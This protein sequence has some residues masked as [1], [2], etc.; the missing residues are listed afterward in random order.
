MGE[1]H[2]AI[3]RG[4]TTLRS[5]WCQESAPNSVSGKKAMTQ[6]LAVNENERFGSFVA[7]TRMIIF[8]IYAWLALTIYLVAAAHGYETAATLQASKILSAELRSGTNYRV[9]EKVSNDGYLNTYHINSK[10]GTFTVVST[11]MLRK[12][13]G[14]VSA[15]VVMEKVKGTSEFTNALSSA[16]NLVTH[17][18]DTL[19]GAATG[20]GVAF[21]RRDQIDRKEV[22]CIAG[23][24]NKRRRYDDVCQ[25]LSQ[26]GIGL[27]AS[28]SNKMKGKE[29]A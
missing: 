18:V 1:A 29:H 14:E 8:V 9:D 28:S 22:R 12:R 23:L 24:L 6:E 16:K 3:L 11:A 19:S 10:F 5:K 21:R 13:I 2:V 7:A 25:N 4:E 20:L 26:V 15:L 27:L 17:P